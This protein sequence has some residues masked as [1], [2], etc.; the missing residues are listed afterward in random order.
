MVV[1]TDAPPTERTKLVELVRGVLQEVCKSRVSV[2]LILNHSARGGMVLWQCVQNY[3]E[4][5]GGSDNADRNSQ[6]S[7][8]MPDS[9]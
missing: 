6:M 1:A 4:C 2:F 9:T 8:H 7:L 5:D 3:G